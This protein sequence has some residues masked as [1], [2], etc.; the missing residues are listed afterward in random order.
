MKIPAI[1]Q[2][3]IDR[4]TLQPLRCCQPAESA[5]QNDDPVFFSHPLAP[6]K[7]PHPRQYHLT[8]YEWKRDGS[9][10]S[11]AKKHLTISLLGADQER[12]A[13]GDLQIARSH[14]L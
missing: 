5:A 11:T 4:R 6:K 14:C 13:F 9:R 7:Q 1:D 8:D 10:I 2:R 3:D 12:D